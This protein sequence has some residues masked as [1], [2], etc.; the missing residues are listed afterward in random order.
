MSLRDLRD[1][2]WAVRAVTLQRLVDL[3]AAFED[4]LLGGLL[5]PRVYEECAQYFSFALPERSSEAHSLV[6]GARLSP[7]V[8]VEF[9]LE[10]GRRLYTVPPQYHG[11]EAVAAEALALLAQRDHERAFEVEVAELPM[12]LLGA[13]SGLGLYG[14]NNLLYVAGMGS[15]HQLAAFYTDE[16]CLEETWDEPLA[17]TRCQD[18]TACMKACPTG[19]IVRDRF[20]LKM[21]R[22]LTLFNEES[23]EFPEWIEPSAHNCPVG[24]LRCQIV[25]PENRDVADVVGATVVFDANETAALLAGATAERLAP[26]LLER[27]RSAGLSDYLSVLPRNLAVLADPEAEAL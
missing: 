23:G 17:M 11:H 13:C 1:S 15:F 9:E 6:I 12:K 19:A 4:L 18:C 10:T 3:E 7:K 21:E 5:T 8:R 16:T 26:D 2:G 25:C 22:C 24:C 20:L 14:R 27:L